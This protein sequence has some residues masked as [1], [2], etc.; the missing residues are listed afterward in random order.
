MYL[1]CSVYTGR[2][3]ETVIRDAWQETRRHQGSWPSIGLHNRLV[4]P[5]RQT[6]CM[7]RVSMFR[8]MWTA[9]STLV[10]LNIIQ[11]PRPKQEI[12]KDETQ[13]TGE[14]TRQ[15]TN[16]DLRSKPWNNEGQR[17]RA[18]QTIATQAQEQRP[19]TRPGI[20]GGNAPQHEIGLNRGLSP[21]TKARDKSNGQ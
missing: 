4:K 19:G 13:G 16:H 12:R 9:H 18:K 5:S 6:V 15:H 10:H 17:S 20:T 2:L 8:I 11:A 14:T 3:D 21:E 7:I 1:I